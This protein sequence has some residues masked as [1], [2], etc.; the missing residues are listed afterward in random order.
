MH[1]VQYLHWSLVSSGCS[2]ETAIARFTMVVFVSV[3]HDINLELVQVA[4]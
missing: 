1:A 3:I 4:G 2:H